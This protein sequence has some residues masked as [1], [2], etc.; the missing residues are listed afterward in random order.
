MAMATEWLRHF[1]WISIINMPTVTNMASVVNVDVTCDK[2]KA[3]R[4]Y[5]CRNYKYIHIQIINC[6]TIDLKFLIASI[7]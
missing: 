6:I 3:M 5:I 1:V 7:Y 4:L 2:L